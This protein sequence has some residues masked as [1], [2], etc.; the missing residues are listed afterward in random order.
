[1]IIMKGKFHKMY[2]VT[3]Q[4]SRN[5]SE[6]PTKRRRKNEDQEETT[7][8]LGK[9]GMCFVQYEYVY[10]N[11]SACVSVCKATPRISGFLGKNKRVN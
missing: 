8:D 4:D 7:S 2:H 11:C 10:C 6:P 3:V 5:T 9:E 1:M